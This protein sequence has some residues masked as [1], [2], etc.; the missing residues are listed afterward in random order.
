MDLE[1]DALGELDLVVGS[2]HSYLNLEAAEM[3]DGSFA[4]L[5]T[6]T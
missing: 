6:R 3:T 5:K 1:D 4:R 2:V